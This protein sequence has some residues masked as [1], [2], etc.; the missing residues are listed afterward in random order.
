MRITQ[1]LT[2]KQDKARYLARIK[3]EKNEKK[4]TRIGKNK[5]INQD[6]KWRKEKKITSIVQEIIILG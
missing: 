3:C 2:R 4:R 1:D 6:C 5:K